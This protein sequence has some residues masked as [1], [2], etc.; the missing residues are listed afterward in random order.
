VEAREILVN[1]NLQVVAEFPK[2]NLFNY[3]CIDNTGQRVYVVV[4]SSKTV[5]SIT[6]KKIERLQPLGRVYLLLISPGHYSLVDLSRVIN[7]EAYRKEKR[8]YIITKTAKRK[9]RIT[10]SKRTMLRITCNPELRDRFQILKVKL[11]LNS[12]TLLARAIEM[13][14]RYTKPL[15]KPIRTEL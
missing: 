15:Q 12:E 8:I 9:I 13:Y 7:D 5:F 6:Q 11:G 14:D 10:H 4:R 2:Y 3:E 1:A